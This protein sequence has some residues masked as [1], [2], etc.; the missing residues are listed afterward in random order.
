MGGGAEVQVWVAFTSAQQL[1]G[2]GGGG[3]L[4][5]LC[6]A[7]LPS[8]GWQQQ[9][10]QAAA[11]AAAGTTVCR[12]TDGSSSDNPAGHTGITIAVGGILCTFE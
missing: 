8:C 1:G 2:F 4:Q 6:V 10:Q 5:W 11:A 3:A 12:G 7:M 9:Q